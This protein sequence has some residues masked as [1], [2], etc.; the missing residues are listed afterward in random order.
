MYDAR[1]GKEN[2]LA[3]TAAMAAWAACRVAAARL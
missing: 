2:V 1:T 3:K